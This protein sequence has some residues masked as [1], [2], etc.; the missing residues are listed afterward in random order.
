MKWHPDAPR[1]TFEHLVMFNL[2]PSQRSLPSMGASPSAMNG[3]VARNSGGSTGFAPICPPSG[4][5]RYRFQVLAL[6]TQLQLPT[7]ASARD[8]A[9]AMAL[10][11]DQHAPPWLE[12]RDFVLGI[13]TDDPAAKRG[14]ELL[15]ACRP[16]GRTATF[17]IY[18]FTPGSDG[19]PVSLP[20]G[21]GQSNTARAP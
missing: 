10:Q 3:M 1:G 8:V 2:P 15:R 16:I 7:G 13:A 21:F 18:D 20:E 6:D 14:L 17:L 12:L 9:S 4:R 5:H 11:M 19:R